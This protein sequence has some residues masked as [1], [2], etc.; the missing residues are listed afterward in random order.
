MLFGFAEL[1][2]FTSD[3]CEI[4][5]TRNVICFVVSNYFLYCGLIYYSN[6]I[7][8]DTFQFIKFQLFKINVY[9]NYDRQQ[10]EQRP[11]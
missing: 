10:Q 8:S 2:L 9:L 1:I 11:S 6:K 7:R 4:N 5:E 3:F